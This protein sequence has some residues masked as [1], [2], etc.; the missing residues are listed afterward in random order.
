MTGCWPTL[1]VLTICL[2]VDG[3]S[4]T[5]GFVILLRQVLVCSWRAGRTSLPWWGRFELFTVYWRT[6]DRTRQVK[7]LSGPFALWT[8]YSPYKMGS[9]APLPLGS[10]AS[11]QGEYCYEVCSQSHRRRRLGYRKCC[12][13]LLY[14]RRGSIRVWLMVSLICRLRLH[15]SMM[16]LVQPFGRLALWSPIKLLFGLFQHWLR[17]GSRARFLNWLNLWDCVL[18]R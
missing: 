2:G 18:H 16:T 5:V 1:R 6:G 9:S 10:G 4:C 14:W 15:S 3:G 7:H 11:S 13:P 17:L 8:Y 12:F